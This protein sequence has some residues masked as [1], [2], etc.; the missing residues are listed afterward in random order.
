MKIKDGYL[1]R[2]LGDAA[3]V[4][5]VGEDVLDFRGM[6]TLNETAAFLW[7]L[8]QTEQTKEHMC[9]ALCAAFDVEPQRAAQD[10]ERFLELL[11]THEFLASDAAVEET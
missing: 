3:V 7:E 9:E 1:L 4:V 8:L 2:K 6:V 11:N 5:A 10:V